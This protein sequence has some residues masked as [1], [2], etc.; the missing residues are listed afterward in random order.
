M[1]WKFGDEPAAVQSEVG[2]LALQ[3]PESSGPG[4]YRACRFCEIAKM[5]SIGVV[6]VAVANAIVKQ[7]VVEILATY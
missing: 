3:I 5:L 4:Q 6:Q 2:P 1:Q 7:F